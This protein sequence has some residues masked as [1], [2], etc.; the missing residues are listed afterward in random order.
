MSD[1]KLEPPF[2]WAGGKR[3]LAPRLSRLYSPYR[4]THTWVEPFVGA[5]GALFGVDPPKAYLNDSNKH[6]IAFFNHVKDGDLPLKVVE[7]PLVNTSN[8]YNKNRAIFNKRNT[9]FAPVN[10]WFFYYLITTCYNGLMR[11]NKKGEFNSPYGGNGRNIKYDL[12]FAAYRAKFENYIFK[13]LDCIAF[14]DAV[15]KRSDYLFTYIDPPYEPLP[16]KQLVRSTPEGFHGNKQT[17]LAEYLSTLPGPVVASNASVPRIEALYKNLGFTIAHV[18]A[19]RNISCNSSTR[20]P[21]PE[22]LAFKNI[23]IDDAL[24]KELGL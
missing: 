22:M 10:S 2:R 16:D 7:R 3:W 9:A 1:Q 4:D 6:L 5:G 12:D 18:Y 17:E 23:D 21:V 14:M 24:A 15:K 13:D 8:E 11:F 20:A 19:R